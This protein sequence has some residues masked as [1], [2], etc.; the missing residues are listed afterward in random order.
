MCVLNVAFSGVLDEWM[1]SCLQISALTTVSVRLLRHRNRAVS[2]IFSVFFFFFPFQT[3]DERGN[4]C[5][6]GMKAFRH[7]RWVYHQHRNN[8]VYGFNVERLKISNHAQACRNSNF[9]FILRAHFCFTV[10]LFQEG[11]NCEQ[12]DGAAPSNLCH[13]AVPIIKR[14]LF[15]QIYTSS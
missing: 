6:H 4:V 11:P 12:T 7:P 3:L 9:L 14:C 8:H 5:F 1:M 13:P 10:L 15:L 2:T